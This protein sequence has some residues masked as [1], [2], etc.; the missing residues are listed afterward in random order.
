ML[1]KLYLLNLCKD[2]GNQEA[3][4]FIPLMGYAILHSLGGESIEKNSLTKYC[5]AYYNLA[6]GV[7]IIT[8]YKLGIIFD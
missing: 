2:K 5:Y 3:Q 7:E 6:P 1:R 8:K 4:Q